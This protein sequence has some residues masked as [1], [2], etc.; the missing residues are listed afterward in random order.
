MRRRA[1]SSTSGEQCEPPP[2]APAAWL[3]LGRTPRRSPDTR[4]EQWCWRKVRG[5]NS[6]GLPLT[7]FETA[8]VAV[9][10]LD[11]PWRWCWWWCWSCWWGVEDSNLCGLRRR[12]YSPV[13]S[14]SM[15][16][17]Q[18]CCVVECAGLTW[19]GMRSGRGPV[20]A[21]ALDDGDQGLASLVV[22]HPLLSCQ[23]PGGSSCPPP[24]KP[25]EGAA[26]A[27]GLEPATCGF[28]DRCSTS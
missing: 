13:Q 6:H 27:T 8:A 5:S 10:R 14:A 15:R 1:R 26:G 12:I 21:G 7:V 17:P 4:P 16:T 19:P 9:P 18:V 25:E 11:P 3:S 24:P 2:R 23:K 28:G 22:L 20:A